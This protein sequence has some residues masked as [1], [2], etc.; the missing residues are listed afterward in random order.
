MLHQISFQ[1]SFKS[2]PNPNVIGDKVSCLCKLSPNI[3]YSRV[4]H[5]RY[6]IKGK[7]NLKV[8]LNPENAQFQVASSFRISFL[9]GI[10]SRSVHNLLPS[11][12]Y[13]CTIS[14]N[15]NSQWTIHKSTI[16]ALGLPYIFPI[17]SSSFNATMP[18]AVLLPLPLP[19]DILLQ[20]RMTK[21]KQVTFSP[22]S[23][24]YTLF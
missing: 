4:L 24:L 11:I 20:T 5:C 3:L 6:I 2:F 18:F 12:P 7:W 14:A 16:S 19:W 17:T 15:R 21:I 8:L 1:R 13:L 9:W 22:I 23:A 10:Q